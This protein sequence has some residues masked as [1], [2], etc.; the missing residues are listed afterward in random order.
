VEPKEIKQ[1]QEDSFSKI[2]D[3]RNVQEPVPLVK[4]EPKERPITP[5]PKVK[6]SGTM[7]ALTRLA[8]LEAQ[9]EYAYAKHIQLMK[10]QKELN[11]QAKILAKLP[12]GVNAFKEDLEAVPQI[13]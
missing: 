2:P 13:A 12:V 8:D 1:A 3:A 6:P 4:E 7:I 9:L 11:L 10:K 5:P